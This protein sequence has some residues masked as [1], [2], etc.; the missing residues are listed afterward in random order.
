MHRVT[1]VPA[2]TTVE[3]RPW[4]FWVRL[5]AT[6]RCPGCGCDLRP[7]EPQFYRSVAYCGQGNCR[8]RIA[9]W[10]KG[11]PE[12]LTRRLHAS[13]TGAVVRQGLIFR[14]FDGTVDTPL[15]NA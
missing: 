6:P 14:V 5:P 15:V 7:L 3:L 10:K 4:R 8:R 9:R 13:T 2:R 11:L 12:A 1:N